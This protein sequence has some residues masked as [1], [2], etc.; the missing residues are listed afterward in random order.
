M[1]AV[2][3]NTDAVSPPNSLPPLW[4][5][6]LAGLPLGGCIAISALPALGNSRAF[7]YD[8]FYLAAFLV[9]SLPLALLQRA[10]WRRLPWW[11]LA[12]TLLVVTYVMAV[13]NNALGF[14]LPYVLGVH[15][16]ENWSWS[17]VFSGLDGCWLPLIAFCAVHAVVNYADALRSAQALRANA[18]ALARDAELRA[19]RLQLQPHFLFNTLNAISAL[20]A[21][22]RDGEA[23]QMLAR[24]GDF[25]RAV[26]DAG[27]AH[28]VALAEEIALTQTY[29]AIEKA[30]LGER[31][32]LEWQIGAGVLDAWVPHLLLQPLVENAIRHGIARRRQPGRLQ[33]EVQGVGERLSLRVF[34]DGAED[35]DASEGERPT[36]GLGNIQAR[37]QQL[38]GAAHRFE[39]NATSVG[40]EVRI[41]LPWR[42]AATALSA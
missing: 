25:L 38:Y 30:R 18:L 33:I 29:L 34:N 28:E 27:D 22:R 23:R 10:L 6:L 14:L 42:R 2:P 26:L 37:L 15:K 8:A 7:T 21:A 24:L 17:G 19:L 39:C 13:A 12:P 36:L 16:S 35:E 4:L 1:P 20:V 9:W 32:R 41:Q 5:P 3:P 40:F 11:W 31:L